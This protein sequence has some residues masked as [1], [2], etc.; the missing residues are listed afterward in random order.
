MNKFTAFAA[1]GI[2]ATT[3]LFAF[4]ASADDGSS[5]ENENSAFAQMVRDNTYDQAPAATNHT[6][7]GYGYGYKAGTLS[8]V[9]KAKAAH[10][11][12][13]EEVR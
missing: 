4:Q 3:A 11:S 9:E 10:K 7:T 5:S 2:M 8:K 1:A 12:T 13:V 6:A